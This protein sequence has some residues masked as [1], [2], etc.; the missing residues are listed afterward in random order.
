MSVVN[1][2]SVHH[3][4]IKDREEGWKKEERGW[5]RR[6]TPSSSHAGTNSET[7]EKPSSRETS[8]EPEGAAQSP[9]LK[10]CLYSGM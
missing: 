3:R 6:R 4:D 10:G 1:S 7:S 8:T 9:I 5:E 2:E